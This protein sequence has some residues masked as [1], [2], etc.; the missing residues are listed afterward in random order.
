MLLARARGGGG[1]QHC[2]RGLSANKFILTL[3]V[4]PIDKPVFD[5]AG[6]TPVERC[7]GIV[8]EVGLVD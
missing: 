8:E 4:A 7:S 1:G 5:V 2:T 3:N 6:G